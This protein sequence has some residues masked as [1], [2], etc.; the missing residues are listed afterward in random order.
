[1][2]RSNERVASLYTPGHPAVLRLI[3]TVVEAAKEAGIGVAVCGEMAGEPNYTLVLLGLGVD[4]FSVSP[5]TLPEIKKVIRSA[6]MDQA[7]EICDKVFRFDSDREVDA[8]LSEI[9]RR[10]LPEMFA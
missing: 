6:T 1:V 2:D 9:S 3:R 8:Y 7:R 10:L 4:G 5:A